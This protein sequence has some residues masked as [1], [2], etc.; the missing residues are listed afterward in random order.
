MKFDGNKIRSNSGQIIAHIDN[1]ENIFVLDRADMLEP[2]R[3]T[4]KSGS[5]DANG[6]ANFLSA[7]TGLNVNLA[8]TAVP[9]NITFANGYTKYGESNRAARIEADAPAIV[10]IPANTTGYIY[11]DQNVTTGAITFGVTPNM[12][13]YGSG[14]A[15]SIVGNQHTYRIDEA[16][17]YVGN[18]ISAVPVR[19]VFIG[20]AT[21]N[22]SAITSVITYGLNGAYESPLTAINVNSYTNFAHNLGLKPRMARTTLVCDSTN[23]G[24]GAGDE[25]HHA[26]TGTS[27][28]QTLAPGI[29]GINTCGVAIAAAV[30]ISSGANGAT[31]SVTTSSWRLRVN[32]ER[33]WR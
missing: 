21:A 31:T 26:G 2:M 33:G 25:V 29:T 13:A 30:I 24:W 32:A 20:Q 27:A 11:C 12:P 19:R 3:Q 17:M 15:K 14:I 6:A 5:I 7:G 8:A 18:G 22:A 10:A 23:A 16:V 4:V 1:E 9:V 28:S